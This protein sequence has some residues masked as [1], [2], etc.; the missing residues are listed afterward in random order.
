MGGLE[1]ELFW[2]KGFQLILEASL[3]LFHLAG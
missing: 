3:I 2:E 1:D